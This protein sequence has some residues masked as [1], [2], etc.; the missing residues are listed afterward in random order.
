ML[1]LRRGKSKSLKNN[2]TI[3]EI[4]YK[5]FEFIMAFQEKLEGILQIYNDQENYERIDL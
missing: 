3:H 1:S 4:L 5:D 2:R